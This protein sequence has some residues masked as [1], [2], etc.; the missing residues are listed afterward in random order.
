MR[1]FLYTLI[2]LGLGSSGAQASTDRRFIGID[3]VAGLVSAQNFSVLSNAERVYQAKDS[4]R[5]ARGNLLPKLNLWRIVGAV[6]DPKGLFGLVEDIVPFLV[7]A[8]W[9][10]A[11]QAKLFAEAQR[12]AY[13]ALWA[14]EVMTAKALFIHAELDQILLVLIERKIE[15]LRELKTIARSREVLGGTP[16]LLSKQI[17]LQISSLQEDVRSLRYLVREELNSLGF[18]LGLSANTVLILKPITMNGPDVFKS[19]SKEAFTT[20]VLTASPELRQ[21]DSLIVAAK[22]ARKE[23]RFTFLGVSTLSRG[24]M[25]GVFDSLPVSDG[26]GFGTAASVRV[27]KREKS[28]LEIQRHAIEES[29]RRTTS[30]TLGSLDLDRESLVGASERKELAYSLKKDLESR[31]R[32]GDPVESS[33]LLSAIQGTVEAESSELSIRYRM[34]VA[35]DRMS[36]L[37]FEGDYANPPSLP[38]IQ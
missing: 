29:L 18:A 7:P 27:T 15:E 17:A 16:E 10:R 23:A 14:N 31:L 6:F 20:R 37:A 35:I 8:N 19:P 11:K 34:L 33:S 32:L 21:F 36:R 13:T 4:I 9:W 5:I 38:S 26:L 28:I 12:E 24:T 22:H 2:I 25:G 30:M 1:N 3:E